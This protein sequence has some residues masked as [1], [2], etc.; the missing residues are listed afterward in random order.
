[1]DVYYGFWDR[2]KRL[3]YKFG[4]GGK[5]ATPPPVPPPPPTTTEIT[6]EAQRAGEVE[7]RRLRGGRRGRAGTIFAGGRDIGLAPTQQAGLKTKLGATA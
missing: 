3:R 2:N 5:T 6:P 1:M 7:R 4:G